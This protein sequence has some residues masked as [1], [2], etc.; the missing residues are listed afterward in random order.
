MP[1]YEC[2]NPLCGPNA[3]M[4][5]SIHPRPHTRPCAL[6][7]DV[8]GWM[9]RFS[10]LPLSRFIRPHTHARCGRIDG[11]MNES[12]H[13]SAHPCA[14]R[15][16]VDGWMSRSIRPHSIEKP[17][18]GKASAALPRDGRE[19]RRRETATTCLVADARATAPGLRRRCRGEDPSFAARAAPPASAARLARCLMWPGWLNDVR[20]WARAQRHAASKA[21]SPALSRA[22]TSARR[23]QEPSGS[24]N[25][26]CRPYHE[27]E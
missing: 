18:V 8:D 17:L 23:L 19:S 7:P 16:D 14:L 15:P 2:T 1:K 10:I 22:T 26:E 12:I 9:S 5:E 4:D 24:C 21:S 3:W 20:C 6:W 25:F 11:R 27:L 13:P